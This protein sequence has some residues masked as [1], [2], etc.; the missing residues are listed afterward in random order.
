ME[1]EVTV[2]AE[3]RATL[4]QVAQHHSNEF[5]DVIALL[6]AVEDRIDAA[7]SVKADDEMHSTLRLVQMARAKVNAAIGDFDQFI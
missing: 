7:S 4:E 2:A 3:C 5:Y 1:A 6:S